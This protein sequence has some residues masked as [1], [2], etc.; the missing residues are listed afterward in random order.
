MREGD[1]VDETVLSQISAINSYSTSTRQYNRFFGLLA[2]IS[3]LFWVA[4]KFI[5]HRGAV[6]RIVLSEESTFALFGFVIVIQTILMAVSFRLTDFT[7]AQNIKAPLNDPTLWAF[8]IPFAFSSLLMTLLADRRTALFTGIFAAFLAGLLAPR[9][10]E[11]ILYA[12]ISSAVAVYGIGQ[13]RSRQSVTIAG[14]FVGVSSAMVAVAL[15][16][17]TQQPLI[18]NTIL[19]VSRMR[20]GKRNN[21]GG[22]NRDVPADLRIAFRNYDGCKIA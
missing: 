3:A 15:I 9:G 5:K 6:S 22:C 13:Y 20:S 11:F 8:A 16:A 12:A 4:W 21:F 18:L 2:L 7:A 10:L 14:A 19:L 1:T 17:Y